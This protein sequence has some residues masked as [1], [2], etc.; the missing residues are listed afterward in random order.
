MG[1]MVQ[2][3]TGLLQFD[4]YERSGAPAPHCFVYRVWDT[5]GRLAYV[6]IA[7]NFERR[8]LQHV[9]LSWWMGE[10]TVRLVVVHGYRSRAE[11]RQV[12]AAAINEE[13][14]VFNTNRETAAY[15]RFLEL[16]DLGSDRPID[17]WDC[18]W[19]SVRRFEVEA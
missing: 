12:E 13:K 4:S 16:Y 15:E 17:D 18:R 5:H 14:P 9:H 8:W 1:A 19:V 10:I 11:A 3:E 6:G 7:E 2:A